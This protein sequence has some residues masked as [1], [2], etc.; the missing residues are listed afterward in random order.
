MEPKTHEANTTTWPEA[1]SDFRISAYVENCTSTL[2][3][4]EQ[5]L[6]NE[7]LYDMLR[8]I[9]VP[10]PAERVVTIE[11]QL[12]TEFQAWDVLSDEALKNFEQEP[13]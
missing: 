9:S 4:R 5:L 11:R 3:M 7:I 12:E 10:L 8:K 6:P 1:G 13:G 2:S